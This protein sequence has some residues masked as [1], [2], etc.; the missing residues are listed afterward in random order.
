MLR[1]KGYVY[2]IDQVRSMTAT[3]IRYGRLVRPD[4]CDYCGKNPSKAKDGRAAI[5]AHHHN[6]YGPGHYLDV[7]WLCVSCHRISHQG[8]NEWPEERRKLAS[9]R[10]SSRT[11]W[12]HTPES[13]EKIRAKR[14]SQ[15]M[16]Q[17]SKET[18]ARMSAAR[19]SWWARRKGNSVVDPD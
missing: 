19:K 3:A 16:P 17:V 12:S 6:G 15:L 5:Q 11:G 9:Q 7:V 2:S 13:V 10:A 4:S 14:A 18:R 8:E 1:P